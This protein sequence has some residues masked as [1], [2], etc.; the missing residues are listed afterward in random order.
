L[1]A[2][3]R[4]YEDASIA[5]LLD[6]EGR[7]LSSAVSRALETRV[8]DV[9]DL[10]RRFEDDDPPDST[11]WAREVEA[12]ASRDPVLRAF[13]WRDAA[14]QPVWSE[15]LGARW[16]GGD[17]DSAYEADRVSAAANAGARPAGAV[18][19][20]FPGP[21]GRRQVVFAAPMLRSGT[22]VGVV[23]AVSRA[24][25]LIDAIVTPEARK[26]FSIGVREGPYRVYGP[27]AS[28]EG[29]EAERGWRTTM[30]QVGDLAWAL[31][32]WPGPELRDRVR[33]YAP[34]LV[35]VSGLL[36]AMVVASLVRQVQLARRRERV[37]TAGVPALD[38]DQ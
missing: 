3:L 27:L 33:S 21:E 23:T 37:S 16:T 15:P 36:L 12:L 28:G 25:D 20:S 30:V 7:Y 13:E 5:R 1:F 19:A 2:A 38:P 18:A 10:A 6:L 17:L 32:Y 11:R 34:P 14:F 35:L 22:R 26:G 24:R 29:R 8:L 9:L 4:A 31:D